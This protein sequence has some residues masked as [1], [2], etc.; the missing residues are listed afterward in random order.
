MRGQCQCL[1]QMGTEETGGWCLPSRE[2]DCLTVGP[3]GTM[4]YRA[5]LCWA[6]AKSRLENISFL[7]FGVFNK[8]H[9][10]IL[11][12]HS[13]AQEAQ[14]M[15]ART[16]KIRAPSAPGA[17]TWICIFLLPGQ[18]YAV[19]P[20]WQLCPDALPSK[21]QGSWNPGQEGTENKMWGQFCSENYLC[22]YPSSSFCST[23]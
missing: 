15:L 3:Q 23:K 20:K 7:I 5:Q 6:M 18:S 12:S 13:P 11:L 10:T 21:N 4:D 2:E 19:Y 1:S 16:A 9:V 8:R 22:I 17:W 14:E